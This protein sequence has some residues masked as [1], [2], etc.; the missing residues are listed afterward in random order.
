MMAMSNL[1]NIFLNF[2]TLKRITHIST[3]IS[4]KVMPITLILIYNYY[5]VLN[6]Y[7]DSEGIS[8]YVSFSVRQ[9]FHLQKVAK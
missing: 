1:T 8:I 7:F 9:I 4:Y 2:T 6:V 5:W 3:C